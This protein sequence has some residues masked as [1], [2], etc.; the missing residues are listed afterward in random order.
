MATDR[1]QELL[2]RML[3]FRKARKWDK[4]AP[5]D[6]A[7]SVMIEAAELLEHFQWDSTDAVTKKDDVKNKDLQ[8][9]SKELGDVLA[10]LSLLAYDL[11][12]DLIA[13]THAKYDHNEIKYPAEQFKNGHNAEFYRKQKAAY[14][15]GK[16]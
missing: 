14:R 2:E 1:Y 8:E 15:A 13:A 12:I 4:I 9:I 16:K 11:G 6:Y 7:K 3:A 5:Q 10:Y